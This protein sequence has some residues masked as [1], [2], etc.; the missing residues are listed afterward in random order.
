MC[1][2]HANT[3]TSPQ[4]DGHKNGHCKFTTKRAVKPGEV[5]FMIVLKRGGLG[6]RPG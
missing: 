3:R 6:G 4:L 5:S 2:V 1:C